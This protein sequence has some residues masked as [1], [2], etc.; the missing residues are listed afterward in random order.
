[1]DKQARGQT[2]LGVIY[3]GPFIDVNP[4]SLEFLYQVLALS[5]WLLAQ[6][7]KILCCGPCDTYRKT[8]NFMITSNAT[9]S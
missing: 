9:V 8:S 5:L 6:L 7:G 4:A 3:E 2:F 1:M